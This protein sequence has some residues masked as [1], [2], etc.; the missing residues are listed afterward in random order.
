MRE[1]F[2][3][4]SGNSICCC[5]ECEIVN[6]WIVCEAYCDS[7]PCDFIDGEWIDFR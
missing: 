6:E 2:D 1:A 4:V 7:L 3:D 5:V